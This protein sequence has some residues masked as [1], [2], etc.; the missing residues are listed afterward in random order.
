MEKSIS[1]EWKKAGVFI[2]IAFMIYLAFRYILPIMF[3]FLLAGVV[4]VLYYPVLNKIWRGKKK[5]W[6]VTISTILLYIVIVLCLGM[7]IYF[8]VK[9]G[10]N[11]VLCLPF[12]QAKIVHVIKD[13]CG[14]IDSFFMM[15]SGSS[16]TQM[17]HMFDGV[18][19]EEISA[20]LQKITSGSIQM[21][22]EVFHIVFGFVITVISTIFILQDYEVIRSWIKQSRFGEG[23]C[24]SGCRLK[25]TIFAYIQAQ[26]FI[27][28]LNGIVCGL[29]FVLIGKP[30]ALLWGF[31]VAVIDMLPVLGL[32][33]ILIPYAVVMFMT[34]RF[35]D[36]I[37][38]L[39][40]YVGC[41]VIRQITEPKMIGKKIGV[42]PICTMLFMYIGFQLFGVI[43][44]LLGP[45]GF[46]LGKELYRGICKTIK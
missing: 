29:A 28:L 25:E 12:Y 4:A 42:L 31:L 17:M 35:L 39:L 9:K 6:I 24:D 7:L 11:T 21:A 43:G 13:C 30:S 22:K 40:A 33:I 45:L 36:G 27:M 16:Y 41:V 15:E 3:P 44:F 23:I 32:G 37:I 14:Q 34:K 19:G 10:T 2:G 20:V 1:K 26:G 5:K 8:L 18:M 46:F 38:L